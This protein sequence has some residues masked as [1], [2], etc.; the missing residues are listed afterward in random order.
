MIDFNSEKREWIKRE[1]G[2]EGEREGG[3]KREGEG[4]EGRER[5]RGREKEIETIMIFI[6]VSLSIIGMSAH[7]VIKSMKQ[8]QRLIGVC[9]L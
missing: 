4:G 6:I 2:R 1:R 9:G 7:Y 3:R 5:K 8:I